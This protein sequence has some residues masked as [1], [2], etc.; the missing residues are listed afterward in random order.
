M[1]WRVVLLMTAASLLTAATAFQ[2]EAEDPGSFPDFPGRD[3]AFG[4]CASCHAFRLVAAQGMTREQWLSSLAWMTERHA[5]PELDAADRDVI[6]DYLGKAF[7][8]K[9]PAGGRGGWRNP[10]QPQ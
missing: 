8:P 6:V 9:A 3:E 4:F 5:M 10:F 2:P 7:P 1:M